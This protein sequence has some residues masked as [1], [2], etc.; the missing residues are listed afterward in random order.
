MCI[1]ARASAVVDV[2]E[3]PRGAVILG[4]SHFSRAAHLSV[5]FLSRVGVRR[6]ERK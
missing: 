5:V 4:V 6:G 1:T 2:G 3:G